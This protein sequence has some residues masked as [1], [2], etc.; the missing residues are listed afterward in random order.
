MISRPSSICFALQRRSSLHDSRG[1][2]RRTTSANGV[3]I[4]RKQ[5]I[6]FGGTVGMEAAHKNNAIARIE[7]CLALDLLQSQC[8]LQS[9]PRD[10]KCHASDDVWPAISAT[11]SM[12]FVSVR[13]ARPAVTSRYSL[14]AESI[15]TEWQSSRQFPRGVVSS[16][17]KIGYRTVS[18][19]MS[20]CNANVCARACAHACVYLD[21]HGVLALVVVAVRCEL[22]LVVVETHKRVPNRRKTTCAAL[23]HG[24]ERVPPFLSH[25]S[26][27]HL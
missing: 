25:V 7:H 8:K 1:N 10:L 11:G 5:P 21:G 13:T 3:A 9:W 2:R 23:Q 20:T 12:A 14:S 15:R 16:H 4:K 19:C 22:G 27:F 17:T 26:A 24:D 6:G 18:G